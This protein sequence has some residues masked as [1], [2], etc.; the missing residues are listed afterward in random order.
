MGISL[1]YAANKW[2]KQ[3]KIHLV[4]NEKN[5]FKID[6][7]VEENLRNFHMKKYFGNDELSTENMRKTVYDIYGKETL[8]I[9]EYF[10]LLSKEN[11]DNVIYKEIYDCIEEGNIVI[12]FTNENYDNFIIVSDG[13]V[14]I[15]IVKWVPTNFIHLNEDGKLLMMAISNLSGMYGM[16]LDCLEISRDC[17]D[18]YIEGTEHGDYVDNIINRKTDDIYKIFK[19]TMDNME[20]LEH[21][22]FFEGRKVRLGILLEAVKQGAKFVY[23]V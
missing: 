21:D 16:S 8:A 22:E 18:S 4:P 2:E 19:F 3:K 6:E 10:E 5:R 12:F 14:E 7:D 20:P 23:S 11:H 1:D 15:E 17:L 9:K 13:L